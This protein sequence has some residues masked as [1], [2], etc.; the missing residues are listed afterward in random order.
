MCYTEQNGDERLGIKRGLKWD[1]TES[2]RRPAGRRPLEGNF[3]ATSGKPGLY[4]KEDLG[5]GIELGA[6]LRPLQ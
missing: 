2:G 6:L 5:V 1:Q 4:S 3:R